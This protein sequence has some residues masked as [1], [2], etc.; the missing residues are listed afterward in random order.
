MKMSENQ[1]NYSDF[2]PDWWDAV[3]VT[4]EAVASQMNLL[5]DSTFCFGGIPAAVKAALAG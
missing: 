5:I 4:A 3:S 1:I 2:A